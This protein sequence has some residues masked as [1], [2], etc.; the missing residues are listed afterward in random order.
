MNYI[1][2]CETIWKILCLLRQV[3]LH[4]LTA[5]LNLEFKQWWLWL[6]QRLHYPPPTDPQA[7][8]LPPSFLHCN[9]EK[10]QSQYLWRLWIKCNMVY[11]PTAHPPMYPSICSCLSR[12]TSSH[13]RGSQVHPYQ[14]PDH[15]KLRVSV[16]RCRTSLIRMKPA[17]HAEKTHFRPIY[18]QGWCPGGV[19]GVTSL[20]GI[21]TGQPCRSSINTFSDYDL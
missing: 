16:W 10:S 13:S 1:C 5:P 9:R 20:C 14:I 12:S 4:G 17:L 19:G 2:Q 21:L 3:Q 18:R 7:T 8:I 15:F 6:N 11:L